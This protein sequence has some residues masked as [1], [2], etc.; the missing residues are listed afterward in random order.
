MESQKKQNIVIITVTLFFIGFI[1]GCFSGVL[2]TVLH[3]IK[4]RGETN[5]AFI[6]NYITENNVI[7]NE[8]TDNFL[9]L[10]TEE[11]N[12]IIGTSDKD[13]SDLDLKETFIGNTSFITIEKEDIKIEEYAISLI[14]N[15]LEENEKILSILN[16]KTNIIHTISK[17]ET[18]NFL[19]ITSIAYRNN[20]EISNEENSYLHANYEID[21]TTKNIIKY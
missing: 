11:T 10:N 21:I 9:N 17:D 16:T 6:E 13:I 4:T 8:E 1:L 14:E 7:N 15:Y 18:G 3:D 19:Y 5:Q 12:E 20:S 2:Y